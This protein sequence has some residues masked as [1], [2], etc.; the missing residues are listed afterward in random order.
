MYSLFFATMLFQ[1]LLINLAIPLIIV[2]AEKRNSDKIEKLYLWSNATVIL[3]ASLL[4]YFF[5]TDSLFENTTKQLAAVGGLFFLQLLPSWVLKYRTN[6]LEERDPSEKP[7]MVSLSF[8]TR[9]SIITLVLVCSFFIYQ[10]ITAGMMSLIKALVLVI[11]CFFMHFLAKGQ[12]KNTLSNKSFEAEK[13]A[14]VLIGLSITLSVYFMAK[15]I[16]FTI[17]SHSIRPIVMS[18]FLQAISIVL[19]PRIAKEFVQK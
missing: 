15:E 10:S 2:M 18:L 11:S 9:T 14:K 19:I 6:S 13:R 3:A 4:I 1:L 7:S 17:D 12:M 16:I 5:F 8:L